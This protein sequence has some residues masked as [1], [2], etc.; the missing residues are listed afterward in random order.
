MQICIE[1]PNLDLVGLKILGW[2]SRETAYIIAL[3][4]EDIEA[5]KNKES[6]A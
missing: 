5:I 1:L 6:F 3:L 4:I 2:Y